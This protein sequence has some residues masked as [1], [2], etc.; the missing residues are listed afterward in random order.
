MIPFFLAKP[1]K[2]FLALMKHEKNNTQILFCSFSEEIIVSLK[3]KTTV[4][5]KAFLNFLLKG[6]K[7]KLMT[8]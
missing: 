4:N 8:S 5:K 6:S 2:S 1:S 3:K 7:G